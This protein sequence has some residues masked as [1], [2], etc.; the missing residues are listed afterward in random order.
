VNPKVG[1][2]S[3]VRIIEAPTVTKKVAVIGGGPA[4]MKAAV[5]AA[6]EDTGLRCMK[7]PA[8]SAACS[9]TRFFK[10]QWPLMDFKDYLSAS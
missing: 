8:T 6:E 5:I 7:R 3:A 1:I 4:G 9:D 2:D 10:L